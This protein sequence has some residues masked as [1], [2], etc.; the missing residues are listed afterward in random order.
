MP[1]RTEPQA[2]T[3]R[4]EEAAVAALLA[5]YKPLPGV[6][7]ELVDGDGRPR[8]HWTSLLAALAEMGVDEVNRRFRAADRHLYRSGVFYRVYDDPNGGERPWPI[9]HLPLVIDAA[10]WRALE[11]GLIQRA[12]MLEGL[13][14]DLYGE[15]QL[16]R[17]GALPAAAVAGNPDFLRPMVGVDPHGGS[18]LKIY[19]ADLGRGP[20]GNW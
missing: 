10:E 4:F 8:A 5:Q 13:L 14:S 16:V 15:G 12:Q 11:R 19:A 9:S 17:A 6:H 18:F 3:R 1:S 20:D 2:R 7:D